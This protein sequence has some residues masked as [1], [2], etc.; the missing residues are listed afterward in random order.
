M[1]HEL[2]AINPALVRPQAPVVANANNLQQR[3]YSYAVRFWSVPEGFAL[4][5]KANVFQAFTYWFSGIPEYRIP[6][7][8]DNEATRC[9]IMPFRKIKL[10]MLP[11]VIQ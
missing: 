2:G 8:G 5:K 9:P 4:P 7:L 10:D 6:G 11:K 1:R 3:L